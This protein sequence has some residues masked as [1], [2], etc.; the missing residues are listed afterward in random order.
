MLREVSLLAVG[1]RTVG[2]VAACI[3]PDLMGGSFFLQT[4]VR[5]DDSVSSLV[6]EPF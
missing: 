2:A 6:T 5:N 1:C 4:L 3:S